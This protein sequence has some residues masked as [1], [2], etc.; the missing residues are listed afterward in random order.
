MLKKFIRIS[1]CI[2]CLAALALIAAKPEIY[3][4]SAGDGLKLWALSV[5][6]SLLPF[7]F[8][9]TL[10]SS[11]G[12]T[13]ALAKILEKPFGALF[14]LRGAC[15]Y[16]FVSSVISGY[17]TG[18]KT[19]AS[20][21]EEGFITADEA[22]RASTLCSTS[23]PSFVIGF[24]GATAF[25][26]KTAGYAILL[27]HIVSAVLCGMAFRFYGKYERRDNRPIQSR[28]LDNALYECAYT[29][30]VAV[31][32]VG[33]FVCVFFT[34]CEAAVNLNLTEPLSRA[35]YALTRD[36]TVARGVSE[37][38][39]ECTRGCRK[40]AESGLTRL[41]VSACAGVISFGGISVFAQSLAFLKKANANAAIFCLSKAVQSA[42]GFSVCYL[43][44]P[45][46]FA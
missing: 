40:I 33:T 36:E 27:S 22:T 28:N 19:I 5:V 42:V 2:V 12:L 15:A 4:K 3:L 35:L 21:A 13:S 20:L 37:G 41:S 9:T 24:I 18:A 25:K 26:N 16:A 34:L 38:I 44:F 17:P 31:A 46:F 23:G 6:P 14:R 10:A 32:V 1:G 43:A 29:S 7:F 8:L 30:V 45:L 11:L 39:I